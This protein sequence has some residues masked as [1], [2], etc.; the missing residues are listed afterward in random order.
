MPTHMMSHDTNSSTTSKTLGNTQVL[1]LSSM[2]GLYV[3]KVQIILFLNQV[4]NEYSY[5]N[6]TFNC[7]Y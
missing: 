5:L 6:V 2:G 4:M 1:L 3:S 7:T